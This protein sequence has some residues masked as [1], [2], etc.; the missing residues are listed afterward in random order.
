MFPRPLLLLLLTPLGLLGAYPDLAGTSPHG[1]QQGVAT[2]LVLTGSRL[3]DFEDLMFATP[4]FKVKSVESRSATKIELT[5]A[6]DATVPYGN[7]VVRVR[8][9]TGISHSRQFFVGPYPTVEEKE[10]NSEFATAQQLAFS[11]TVEGVVQNEDVDYYKLTA[12]KG[13]R[14][15]VEI[16]GMRLATIPNGFFDPYLAILDKDKFEKAF[17]DDSILH[18]ADGY[19]SFV[20]EYDGDY[21]VMVR[22]SSYKGSGNSF[23]RLHVGSFFRPDAVY[24]AGGKIGS[25]LQVRF[26]DAKES[27]TENVTLPKEDDPEFQLLVSGAGKPPSGNPFRLSK[28]ENT[29]EAEPNDTAAQATPALAAE[30]YAL[31]GII[32]QP[33]DVDFFRVPM[34]KGQV[35]E[36]RGLS[37]TIG[38]PLDP[39]VAIQNPKGGSLNG[40]DDGGGL[41]R[42]DS[43]F[44]ITIPADGDYTVSVRDHLERGGNHFVYR[45][46]MV[47]SQPSLTFASPDYTVNDTQYRQFMAVP[48]GGRMVLQN[49][50]TR[51]GIGGDF[52]YEA[53]SLPAGVKLL[54]SAAPGNLPGV[55]L[56]LEAAEDAPLAGGYTAIRLQPVDPKVTITGELRRTFDIVRVGNT[57]YYQGIED[58]LPVAV[59]EKAPFSLEIAKPQVPLVH[60]GI[61]NLKV[62]AKRVDG[63]KGPIRVFM[64][65]T[66]PGVASLGEQTIA[67]DSNECIFQLSANANVAPQTWQFIV[68]GEADAGGGRSF[69]ASPFAELTTEAP[70]VA[71]NG[72]PLTSIVVGTTGVMSA[73]LEVPRP[74]EGEAVAQL[75][76]LP[77][78]FQVAPIKVTKA[79]KDVTF[80]VV[81]TDKTPLGKQ[82]NLFVQVDVPTGKGVSTHR[83]ALG[84]ILRVDAPPKNAPKPV[85][86][87]A[88]VGKPA[89][90][91][92]APVQLSRLEQLRQQNAAPKN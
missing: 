84:S 47:A 62:S 16:D 48:R 26:V 14:I 5:L 24:P 70:Y 54:T 57:I 52:R 6:V 27:V 51:N 13:Q 23:Y 75:V 8:T 63:F 85:P 25:Q 37:Q 1:A 7:H 42:L 55:P 73:N 49:N 22:E 61:Y 64:C 32:A 56:V 83:I 59:V 90:V 43:K 74:F 15:S 53:P 9:K 68:Q 87:A 11:Q 89:V 78:T 91:V 19:C 20:A 2:K 30:A 3:A 67:E 44:K 58:T 86:V 18:R 81:T 33:G 72:I 79:T 76:G 31:N 21:Y 69:N 71:A 4:G 29:L 17:A 45:I 82:Q 60:N 50:F 34:K 10:P 41:R 12:K 88:V 40:N 36:I 77:D 80:Q 28:A 65:W 92:A 39:V 46:E 38:S 35:W 66:P